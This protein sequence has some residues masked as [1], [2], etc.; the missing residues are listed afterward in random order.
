MG[1]GKKDTALIIVDVQ[2]RF[3]GEGENQT[4]DGERIVPIINGLIDI[5]DH[6]IVAC[7]NWIP[8]CP[9][10]NPHM[11]LKLD[12]RAVFVHK[13]CASAF[14]GHVYS[15]HR[16][17]KDDHKPEFQ[18]LPLL[19]SRG[20]KQIFVCGI[21]TEWC[22]KGT[23]LSAAKEGFTT[24]LI[25][26]A[27]AGHTPDGIKLAIEEMRKEKVLVWS[28]ELVEGI[29]KCIVEAEFPPELATM[30]KQ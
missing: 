4:K 9:T 24:H 1:K 28:N 3:I 11:G 27:C 19:K 21:F 6:L 16:D 25:E 14:D 5:F 8:N 15:A 2:P 20:V 26:A 17:A 29:A 12:S 30:L 10:A 22:V 13:N 7:H 23:A 18:L